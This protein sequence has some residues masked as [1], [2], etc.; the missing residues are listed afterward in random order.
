MR[1]YALI[2][3]IFALLI[4]NSIMQQAASATPLT[5]ISLW[6]QRFA[7][8]AGVA[9]A[10][11][12]LV[13]L[14]L[15]AQFWRALLPLC[16]VEW[17]PARFWDRLSTCGL[18]C[19]WLPL[20][21]AQT[22]T[23]G[24]SMLPMGAPSRW[25]IGA[26][27][28]LILCRMLAIATKHPWGLRLL[29][30][31]VSAAAALLCGLELCPAIPLCPFVL[32]LM[33]AP[34]LWLTIARNTPPQLVWLLI[35]ALG[36]CTY[37]A[38]FGHLLVWYTPTPNEVI[39]PWGLWLGGLFL[40]CILLLILLRTLRHA[41]LGRRALSLLLLIFGAAWLWLSFAPAQRVLP[42]QQ[43]AS[44]GAYAAA[45]VILGIPATLLMLDGRRRKDQ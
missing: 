33:L 43:A 15:G 4:I 35:A 25:L 13:L 21:C 42:A 5:N 6:E 40:A 22:Y 20:L 38:A 24:E 37:V 19:G 44:L 41:S 17:A 29:V 45:L 14:G 23:A 32:G 30:A 36:F 28:A 31:L 27:F 1:R 7:L 34:A 3:L 39:S 10:A 26:F 11:L 18:W 9:A 16:G 12:Y 8:P 2:F